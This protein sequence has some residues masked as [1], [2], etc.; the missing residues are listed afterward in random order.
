MSPVA[1]SSQ[2]TAPRSPRTRLLLV[3]LPLVLVLGACALA[4]RVPVKIALAGSPGTRLERVV[5]ICGKPIHRWKAEGFECLPAWPCSGV[6]AGGEVLF[7][8]WLG[9][10]WYFFFDTRGSLIRTEFSGS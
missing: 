4:L 8:G 3:F 2:K 1:V 7:Y 6:H 5:E 10:G 9:M